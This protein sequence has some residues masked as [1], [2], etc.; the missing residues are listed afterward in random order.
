MDLL[1]RGM[2]GNT[3]T[4]IIILPDSISPLATTAPA[5]PAQSG[6]QLHFR[7]HLCHPAAY[8]MYM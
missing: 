4:I 8:I 1:S 6:R 3:I 2:T 7:L 5:C